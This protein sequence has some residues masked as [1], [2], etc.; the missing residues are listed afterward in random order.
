MAQRDV[1][2]VRE[3]NATFNG[4]P[5][6]ADAWLEFYDPAIEFHM[7]ERWPEEP[8]YYGYDGV[9]RAA[10]LWSE[11]FDDYR[12]DE[13]RLIDTG[14]CVVGLWHTRGRIKQGG[15]WIEAPVGSIW[16][17]RDGKVLRVDTYFTWDEALDAAGLSGE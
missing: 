17:V 11:N 6:N 8:V 10:A 13:E 12:W 2:V 15:T 14:D 3:L 9:R 5:K 7:P 1:E 4:D 16:H